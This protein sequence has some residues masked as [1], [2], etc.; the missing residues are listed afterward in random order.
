MWGAVSFPPPC[1]YAVALYLLAR[2]ESTPDRGFRPLRPRC[3]CLRWE[4][5]GKLCPQEHL[6]LW[7]DRL[8]LPRACTFGGAVCFRS[9]PLRCPRP[10]LWGTDGCICW[11]TDGCEML[12]AVSRTA[13]SCGSGPRCVKRDWVHTGS[14]RRVENFQVSSELP[15]TKCSHSP[16]GQH[17]NAAF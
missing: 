6:V 8:A 13:Q 17:G 9:R 14:S 2:P 16:C 10:N 3:V 11:G 12:I 5:A 1:C 4:S 15:R 7:L